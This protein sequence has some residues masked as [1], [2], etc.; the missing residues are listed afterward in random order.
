MSNDI[1]GDLDVR[2]ALAIAAGLVA[3]GRKVE[4]L[5]TEQRA[6]EAG[7]IAE[8]AAAIADELM[9]QRRQRAA[10]AEARR[11]ETLH[12]WPTNRGRR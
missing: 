12:N 4:E 6:I 8:L 1:I 3:R 7:A 5:D 11:Q 9:V 2:A 10:T